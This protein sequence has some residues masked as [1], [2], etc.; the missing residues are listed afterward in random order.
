MESSATH[1]LLKKQNRVVKKLEEENAK[2]AILAWFDES[3]WDIDTL[4]SL[5]CEDF[6]TSGSES[7]NV[8]RLVKLA[9]TP[10]TKPVAFATAWKRLRTE[11][12]PPAQHS[13]ESIVLVLQ[14]RPI[15]APRRTPSPTTTTTTTTHSGGTT[16]VTTTTSSNEPHVELVMVAEPCVSKRQC[17]AR[18]WGKGSGN[19]RC[20]K[21]S[22]VGDYC[23]SHHNKAKNGET[24]C[25]LVGGQKQ[26]LW[27]G[28]IDTYQDGLF[29]IPPYKDDTGC[30]RI[31]WNSDKMKQIVAEDVSRGT[32][33]N[34]PKPS[35]TTL[36]EWTFAG[37]SYYIEPD[38][39]EIYNRET[40]EVIGGWR[41]TRQTGRPYIN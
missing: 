24:P 26:G 25:K 9:L 1:Q 21:I 6:C 35:Q 13:E 23:S 16:T 8:K 36:E 31:V 2:I 39:R 10:L 7:S 20:S 41:G 27:M 30:V 40:F 17:M 11:G 34:E 3:Q 38:S 15:P 12:R 28:R 22:T 29:G 37:N 33:F 32:A 18:I 5:P 4:M 14:T 19:D